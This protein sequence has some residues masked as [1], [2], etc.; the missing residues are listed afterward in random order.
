MITVLEHTNALLEPTEAIIHQCN[1]FGVMG[2]GF[3]R[4]LREKYP[5]AAEADAAT[6]NGCKDKLGKFSAVKTYDGKIIFNL[7]SQYRYGA[8]RR[9]TDYEAFY[10]ALAAARSHM[11]ILGLKTVVMPHGIGCGLA[12]GSWPIVYAMIQEV[13]E[14]TGIKVKLCKYP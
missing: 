11:E 1:C 4:V 2:G 12:G 9:H 10:T 6:K 8:D 13:F 5:E 7:Y 3:A 14:N